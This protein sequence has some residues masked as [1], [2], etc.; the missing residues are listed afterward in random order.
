MELKNVIILGDSLLQPIL[1]DNTNKYAVSSAVDWHYIEQKLN[2]KIK[3][4]S[5]M[6]ATIKH[7]YLYLIDYLKANNGIHAAIIEYGG[8]DCDY[9]WPKVSIDNKVQHLPR[10]NV[11][12][13]ENTLNIM[14]DIL[15]E[16]GIKTILTTLPP[17][18]SPKYYDWITKKGLNKEN[19]M[20]HLG[21][22]EAISRHQEYYSNIIEK[23]ANIRG[24]D[25]V[26][27]RRDFLLRKDY[28]N[29]MCEDGVH[30]N[31]EG[32]Q[33]IVNTFLGKYAN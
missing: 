28:I 24:V 1:I 17:I 11:K 27:L 13:F 32:E 15:E 33:I 4:L 5:K 8:N 2:I 29:L 9:N 22:I 18:S 14:I 3:N 19:I 6:G 7:G 23:T 10:T 12:E 31:I 25:L 21:D 20:L 16:K 26:D 30:P